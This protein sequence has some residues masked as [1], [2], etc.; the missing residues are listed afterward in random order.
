[1]TTPD[2]A[3]AA[4]QATPPSPLL[5]MNLSVAFPPTATA[6][7]QNLASMLFNQSQR[8]FYAVIA[9]N[10]PIVFSNVRYGSQ[11]IPIPSIAP[12]L[13]PAPGPDTMVSSAAAAAAA[14]ESAPSS[15]AAIESYSG[16]VR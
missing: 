7:A 10:G 9:K 8:E 1:M 13:A 3:E 14:P 16:P 5:A 12:V 15:G 4:P 2:P 11:P 6:A